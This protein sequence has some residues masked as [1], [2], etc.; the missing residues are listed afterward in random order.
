MFGLGKFK[1]LV[2]KVDYGLVKVDEVNAHLSLKFIQPLD[3]R[4]EICL[5]L[6]KPDFNLSNSDFLLAKMVVFYFVLR[7][8]VR[9]RCLDN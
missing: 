4:G 9:C 8:T 7:L 1:E 3:A 5:R 6:L 2:V